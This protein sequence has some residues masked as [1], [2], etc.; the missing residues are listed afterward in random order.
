MDSDAVLRELAIDV[1]L[2][3]IPVHTTQFLL[4]TGRLTFQHKNQFRILKRTDLDHF[5]LRAVQA[6]GVAVHE[7][8]AV[9]DVFPSHDY[10]VVRTASA[11]YKTKILI[12]AD[13][14]NSRVR[15]RLGM[16]RSGRMM[17]AIELHVPLEQVRIQD[18]SS[19]M[20]ILDL[21]VLNDGVPGYCW[22]FPTVSDNAQ[23]LSLGLMAAPF[24]HGQTS[25]LKRFFGTWL[26]GF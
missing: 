4:P 18:F 21:R 6:R 26:N 9:L 15:S 8:E 23:I 5:L 13:G 2:P 3:S 24:V 7:G 10:V 11:E 12:A 1:D 14:A 25:H 19:N 16:T 22:V 20:A 17:V